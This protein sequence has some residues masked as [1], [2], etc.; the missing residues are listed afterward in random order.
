MRLCCPTATCL[1][2]L[3]F[4]PSFD[5]T[6]GLGGSGGS[7]VELNWDGVKVW[8]MQDPWMHHDYERTLTGNTFYLLWEPMPAD[9]S[10]AGQGRCQ[11]S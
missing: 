3:R 9:L 4:R 8:E 11:D 1:A 2:A 5:E 7:I 10:V 6:R